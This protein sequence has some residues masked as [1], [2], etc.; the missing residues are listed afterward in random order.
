MDGSEISILQVS[1]VPGQLIFNKT[2]CSSVQKVSFGFL[3]L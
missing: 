3:L 2:L 1:F